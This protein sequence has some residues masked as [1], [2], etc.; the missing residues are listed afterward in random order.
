MILSTSDVGYGVGSGEA[1][2]LCMQKSRKRSMIE[3][4]TVE[5]LHEYA[6]MKI[7]LIS[8]YQMCR[9]VDRR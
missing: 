8:F 6:M 4:L 1:A 9:L 5:G 2:T 7:N 3:M